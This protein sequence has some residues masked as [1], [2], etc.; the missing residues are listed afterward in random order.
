MLKVPQLTLSFSE[1]I[2][3]IYK[4]GII[5]S[6]FR[7]ILRL[8]IL[9]FTLFSPKKKTHPAIFPLSVNDISILPFPWVKTFGDIFKGSPF[10]SSI[11]YLIH[12]KFLLDLLSQHI[13]NLSSY[14]HY[15]IHSTLCFAGQDDSYSFLTCPLFLSCHHIQPTH[16]F[17]TSHLLWFECLF[18][19]PNSCLEILKP[20]VIAV[21][22]RTVGKSLN[23]E[24]GD[25]I[26]KWD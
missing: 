24:D 22:V 20:S 19:Q 12:Q 7:D 25:F 6:T 26:I 8:E 5:I 21:G 18:P 9:V 23:H 1:H 13:H 10:I 16:T 4:V 15:C 17:Q 2:I 14:H 3:F 11:P